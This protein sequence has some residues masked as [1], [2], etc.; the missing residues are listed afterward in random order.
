M[1]SLPLVEHK[2]SGRRFQSP[3]AFTHLS[4]DF[5]WRLRYILRHPSLS[6]TC[7]SAKTQRRSN[8]P[9]LAMASFAPL[10]VPIRAGG[11]AK[12]RVTYFYDVDIGN[13]AYD[14]QHPMKPHRIRLAHSLIMNYG[15]YSKME[16][17][18]R[19]TSSSHSDLSPSVEI[20]LHWISFPAAIKFVGHI[21]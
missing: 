12:K 6:T 18:V 14:S 17:Y 11:R 15:L 1:I 21:Y 9:V 5:I 16:I 20:C 8:N 4:R 2:H 3:Y 19:A 10:D 13:Y 7:V